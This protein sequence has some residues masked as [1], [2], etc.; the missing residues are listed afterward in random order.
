MPKL[1][2]TRVAAITKRGR[3]SDGFGL[4]LAVT[5]SLHK[6]FQFRYQ[7][8]GKEHYIG[9]GPLH[10]ISLEEARDLARA[11]RKKL[12]AGVDLIAER[13]RRERAKPTPNKSPSRKQRSAISRCMKASG[14]TPSTARNS[15]RH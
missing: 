1:S 10:T 9:L 4:V 5:R 12:L 2:D 8:G 6:S 14:G 15:S 11:L 3:Y 13:R 7:R